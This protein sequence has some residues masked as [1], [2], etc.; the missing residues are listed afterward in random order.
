VAVQVTFDDCV[1]VRRCL[2]DGWAMGEIGHASFHF[3]G[4]IGDNFAV[5][6]RGRGM[7]VISVSLMGRNETEVGNPSRTADR[8]G[9]PPSQR[10]QTLRVTDGPFCRTRPIKH[11]SLYARLVMKD[12][13]CAA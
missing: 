2:G 12:P 13:E 8:V 6:V 9:S 3:E 11:P 10:Y 7:R 4:I 5:S 1:E